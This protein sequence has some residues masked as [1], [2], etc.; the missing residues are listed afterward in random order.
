M[1]E[2][3]TLNVLKGKISI[4]SNQNKKIY[5]SEGRMEWELKRCRVGFSKICVPSMLRNI[6]TSQ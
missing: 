1:K 4:K 5:L 6:H 3:M 2:N